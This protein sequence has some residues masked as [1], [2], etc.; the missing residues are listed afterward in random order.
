MHVDRWVS[1]GVDLAAAE[2]RNTGVAAL[3]KHGRIVHGIVHTDSEILGFVV[4]YNPMVVVVDSPLSLPRG[5]LSLH[6][7][8][9]PHLRECDRVLL[10]RG[11]RF[12]PVT[13]GSMRT[14]T[15]RGM[16]LADRLRALGYNVYEGFP[17]GAQ[18]I[19]G[20]PRKSKGVAAMVKGLRTLGLQA[21][22]WTHDELDAA[23]CAYVG[24]LYLE[25]KA[26]LIGDSDEGEMLLPKHK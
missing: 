7:R 15:E 24:L 11:I 4:K 9:G 16:R 12:L 20:V 8:G 18:D 6:A 1:V 22:L 10:K 25:G 3:A 19:L 5:R 17:G 26:E 14:L 13:L 2:H 23:T 21:G